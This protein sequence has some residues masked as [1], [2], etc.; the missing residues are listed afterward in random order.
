MKHQKVALA[1]VFVIY[2]ISGTN[3]FIGTTVHEVGHAMICVSNGN[4]VMQIS[5]TQT[6]CNVLSNAQRW[7]DETMSWERLWWGSDAKEPTYLR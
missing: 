4:Q 6:T 1:I 7:H 3:I 2:M 5:A